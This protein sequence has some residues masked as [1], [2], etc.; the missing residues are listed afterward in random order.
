VIII[1]AEENTSSGILYNYYWSSKGL[2]FH[3]LHKEMD[4]KN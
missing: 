3:I 1:S 2:R 4:L